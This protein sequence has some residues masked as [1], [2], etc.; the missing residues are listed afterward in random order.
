MD[1]P[2]NL[3]AL[4]KQNR[5]THEQILEQYRMTAGQPLLRFTAVALGQEA[6]S[7]AENGRWLPFILCQKLTKS[8]L[9]LGPMARGQ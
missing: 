8:L 3:S 1:R 6:F 2:V 5:V 7:Q 9:G 4:L